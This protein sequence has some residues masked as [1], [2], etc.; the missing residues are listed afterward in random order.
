M[1]LDHIRTRFL[2][3]DLYARATYTRVYT[4]VTFCQF[5]YQK[6]D[7][8]ISSRWWSCLVKIVPSVLS[9]HGK[10]HT[11]PHL[12]WLVCYLSV[13]GSAN[14]TEPDSFCCSVTVLLTVLSEFHGGVDTSFQA[15]LWRLSGAA[16]INI[17]RNWSSKGLMFFWLCYN[18]VS[19]CHIIV[20][21][22]C[23]YSL[24]NEIHA[25]VAYPFSV[26]QLF[27]ESHL[28]FVLDDMFLA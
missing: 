14:N 7:S 12:H 27:G 8:V 6:P 17:H 13:F 22:V 21:P 19:D 15:V 4:V 1:I 24:L 3:G 9:Y 28:T 23:F 20:L 25:I 11:M 18:V 16:R 26:N 10:R 2:G 5:F